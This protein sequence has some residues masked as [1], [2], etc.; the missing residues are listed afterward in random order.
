MRTLRRCA[1]SFLSL[2]ALGAISRS[3]GIPAVLQ[4]LK[5][6]ANAFPEVSVRILLL[7]P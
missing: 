7:D 1:I 4:I 5:V 3:Q 6:D 2:I